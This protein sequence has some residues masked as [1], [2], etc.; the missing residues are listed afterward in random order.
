MINVVIRQHLAIWY[1]TI[2]KA[3]EHERND[4]RRRPMRKSAT[5]DWIQTLQ[6]FAICLRTPWSG[7]QPPTFVIFSLSQIPFPLKLRKA[8]NQTYVELPKQIELAVRN[9]CVSQLVQLLWGDVRPKS[10]TG[11]VKRN[12]LLNT[13]FQVFRKKTTFG[14]SKLLFPKQSK[15]SNH[16]FHSCHRQWQK[17]LG[18]DVVF[19]FQQLCHVFI[20]ISRTAPH[21]LQCRRTSTT[22]FHS[23]SVKEIDKE[24]FWGKTETHIFTVNVWRQRWF[25]SWSGWSF[26]RSVN[27]KM[28]M[29]L[30]MYTMRIMDS[31]A[32]I[33]EQKHLQNCFFKR[34]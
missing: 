21:M 12:R 23:F 3:G 20:W 31:D 15:A 29:V 1:T 26:F 10:E 30:M 22:V 7:R 13:G 18:F 33:K 28:M 19:L 4:I 6:C 16:C 9:A 2:S 5:K 32:N 17:S 14:V 27:M 11:F 8:G 24:G 25:Y 34:E